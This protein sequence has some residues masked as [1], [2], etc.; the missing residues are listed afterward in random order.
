MK[1]SSEI[2]S[3]LEGIDGLEEAE[4]RTNELEN[5]VMKSNQGEQ[6]KEKKRIIK[7][8]NRLRELSDVIK[9][10]GT[11]SSQQNQP[12]QIHTKTHNN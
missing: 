12:N 2:E 9:P 3:T 1:N 8:G 4:E 5:R 11:E 7:D 10:G 6:Q